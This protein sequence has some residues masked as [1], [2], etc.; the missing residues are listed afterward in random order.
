[1]SWAPKQSQAEVP[2]Y[3]RT[4][5]EKGAFIIGIAGNQS[6]LVSRLFLSACDEPSSRLES[7]GFFGLPSSV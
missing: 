6:S 2:E 4:A 3:L 7:F 1:M 5:R